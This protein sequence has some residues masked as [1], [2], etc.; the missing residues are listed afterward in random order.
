[1]TRCQVLRSVPDDAAPGSSNGQKSSVLSQRP[2][3]PAF[4]IF[5]SRFCRSGLW[6][7][8]HPD[9]CPACDSIAP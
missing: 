9:V 1:M 6:Q 3:N 8:G 4:I 2:E 5:V 7:D